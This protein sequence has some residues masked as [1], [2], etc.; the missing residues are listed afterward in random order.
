MATPAGQRSVVGAPEIGQSSGVFMTLRI[1]GGVFGVAV[2]VAVFAGSGSH[3]SPEEFGGDFT[4]A[5]GT[6]VAF[7]FTGL[8]VA[9]GMPGRRPAG[10]PRASALSGTDRGGD[11]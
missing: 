4:A 10:T 6:V 9:L 1:F 2:A 8:L 11:R 5:M 3:G 7:A